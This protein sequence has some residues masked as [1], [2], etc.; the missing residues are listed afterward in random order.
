MRKS[1][2]VLALFAGLLAVAGIASPAGATP[3]IWQSP[4]GGCVPYNSSIQNDGYDVADTGGQVSFTTGTTAN[5]YFV[6]PVTT[7]NDGKSVGLRLYATD[8]DAS[9]TDTYV[10]ATLYKKT[11]SGGTYTNICSVTSNGSGSWVI[12]SSGFCAVMDTDTDIYWVF[13]KMVRS[14]TQATKFY[15]VELIEEIQ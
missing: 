10:Q 9:G 8:A 7:G 5:Q 3:P 14:G 12:N 4:A 1:K 6:C 11:R 2:S 13:V 15:A